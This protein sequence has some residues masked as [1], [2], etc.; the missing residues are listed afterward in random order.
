MEVKVK[1]IKD[2]DG[3]YN[4]HIIFEFDGCKSRKQADKILDKWDKEVKADSAKF[5]EEIKEDSEEM[6][7]RLGESRI[8]S[9]TY[10]EEK[11]KI[12]KF[13]DETIKEEGERLG[14]LLKHLHVEY[15]ETYKHFEENPSDEHESTDDEDSSDEKS[16]DDKNADGSK[17]NK[18]QTEDN[19]SPID[20]VLEKQGC[21]LPDISDSDGDG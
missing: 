19:Q 9:K 4:D 14:K 21:E 7:D 2:R 3:D 18:N 10:Y 17:G 6:E 5:I 1:D 12:Q 20:Y 16:S 8:T 13:M 15:E 11:E